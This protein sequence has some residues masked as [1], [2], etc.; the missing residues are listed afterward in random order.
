MSKGS[1]WGMAMGK[2]I[3]NSDG[4]VLCWCQDDDG[5]KIYELG[6]GMTSPSNEDVDFVKVEPPSTLNDSNGWFKF[7]DVNTATVSGAKPK[8]RLDFTF[9]SA[10]QGSAMSD[11]EIAQAGGIEDDLEKHRIRGS[12]NKWGDQPNAFNIRNFPLPK[13]PK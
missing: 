6:P 3:N 4:I 1:F 13:F 7:S 10:H 5:L 12:A 11:S 8:L 9:G 2:V